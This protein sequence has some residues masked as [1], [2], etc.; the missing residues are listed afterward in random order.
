[1]PF[2]EQHAAGGSVFARSMG[3]ARTECHHHVNTWSALQHPVLASNGFTDSS[4]KF[5][6]NFSWQPP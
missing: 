3:W 4:S 5:C 6:M 1:M 2:N